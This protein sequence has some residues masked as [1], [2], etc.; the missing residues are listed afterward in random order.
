MSLQSVRGTRDLTGD[1][2]RSFLKIIAI[3]RRQSEI[4]GFEEIETPIFEST[5]VFKRTLGD[6][7]DIVTKEMYTFIDKSGDSLTL[8][9]EGTASVA[10]S[11]IS[12]NLFRDLP[13]KYFYQGPMFR[14]ERPQKGRYRQFYQ[15][16]AE[17]VGVASPIADAEVIGLAWNILSELG[18]EKNISL[19]INS[20]GDTESRKNY[21]EALSTYFKGLRD[22]LSE[23]S[24]NRIDKNPLRIL[25]SKSEQDKPFVEKAPRM[26][27]FLNETSK[28]F[29][30]DLQ[31][32]LNILNIPFVINE[33]LVRGLDYYCHTVFEFT[34]KD[35][36]AQNAVLSGG[37][38]DGLIEM[39]GGPSTPAVGWAAGVDRL[40]LLA[41]LKHDAPLVIGVVPLAPEFESESLRILQDLRKN[42]IAAQMPYTGNLSKR[43][44][45]LDRVNC[46]AAIIVGGEEDGRGEVQVKNFKGGSGQS[47]N[48]KEL[49]NFLKT[50]IL[51]G[52]F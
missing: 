52:I 19:E 15:M 28:S 41:Q 6:A 24:Q 3:A 14:H 50:E 42:K 17:L 34:T 37:R 11:L 18:L 33:K 44:K 36:G 39:M 20:L 13:I 5:E 49:L 43:L 40:T 21:R 38:Y 22:Q 32:Y 9:P 47:V 29:F 7:S 45:K 35:L 48:K 23:E 2:I 30:D 26:Q 27:D 8:R 10:R 25:D 31:K 12:Q 4:Y 1:E 46:A 51:N 16:G